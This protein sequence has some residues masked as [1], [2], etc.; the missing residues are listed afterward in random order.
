MAAA[1]KNIVI[2]EGGS[3]VGD[4]DDDGERSSQAV[5]PPGSS[6]P[7]HVKIDPITAV[8]DSID[9]LALSLFEALRGVRDGVAP[10]AL[11][12]P[13]PGT[14]PAAKPDKVPAMTPFNS[15]PIPEE[16]MD[17]NATVKDELLNELNPDYFPPRAFDLLEPEYDSFVLSHLCGNQYASELADRFAR[18]EE[19]QMDAKSDLKGDNEQTSSKEA[20][21]D[22]TKSTKPKI[23]L[24]V[25]SK[26]P[27]SPPKEKKKAF[28]MDQKDY[29]KLLLDTEHQ[30]D[31]QTTSG[32]ANDIL[33]KSKEVD[34]LVA[35]LPGMDRTRDQQLRRI[36]E[37]I[38][39]NHAV[40]KELDEAYVTAKE[41]R[42]KVRAAL[43]ESTCLALGIEEEAP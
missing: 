28:P 35:N 14:A 8:Q 33:A 1:T 12:N 19:E 42:E 25:S 29:T 5:D 39:S 31:I 40:S 43:E 17:R 21:E 22:A 20:E 30:R 13:H 9:S 41:K 6:N 32:L 10:E 27:V 16:E 36:N 7:A 23:K 2:N 24:R 26:P 37:L 11:L 3:T 18:L 4:A 34:D 15:E 38:T